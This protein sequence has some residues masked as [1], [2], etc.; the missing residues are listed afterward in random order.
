MLGTIAAA[1]SLGVLVLAEEQQ[2][3]VALYPGRARGLVP[4]LVVVLVAEA[5]VWGVIIRLAVG[6]RRGWALAL[7]GGSCAIAS[8]LALCATVIAGIDHTYPSLFPKIGSLIAVV[9]DVALLL[10]FVPVLRLARRV[11][12]LG[13]AEGQ[14]DVSAAACA[15][16][17]AVGGVSLAIAPWPYFFTPC[18]VVVLLALLGGRRTYVLALAGGERSQAR[19]TMRRGFGAGAA[20]VLLAGAFIL[21]LR[22]SEQSMTR[23]PA[24]I[25]IYARGLAGRCE[26]DGAG[27]EGD[28]SL[29][30][31]DCG[32]WRGAPIGWDERARVVLQ[33]EQLYQRV[34]RLRPAP[35]AGSG[36]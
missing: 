6:A 20:H 28:I 9:A 17:A 13:V 15:W 30:L 35:P 32:S 23:N 4:A 3:F 11:P 27:H 14:L 21:L 12:A 24:V 7:L 29:W 5:V 1:C 25:G 8:L 10:S 2:A 22:L 16:T 26:V 36:R 31:V 33:D 18:A 34:P 19:A